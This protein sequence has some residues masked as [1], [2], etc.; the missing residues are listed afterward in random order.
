M[1]TVLKNALACSKAKET[2]LCKEQC[3]EHSDNSMTP[4]VD[5]HNN[6]GKRTS[7]TQ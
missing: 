5:N 3:E 6:N 7:I 4:V 1:D 2:A